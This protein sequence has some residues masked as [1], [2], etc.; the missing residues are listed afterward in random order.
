VL[1]RTRRE[2]ADEAVRSE[3]GRVRTE[4]L[5]AGFRHYVAAVDAAL[6]A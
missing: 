2:H 4:V 1:A 3:L 5:Q 6:A